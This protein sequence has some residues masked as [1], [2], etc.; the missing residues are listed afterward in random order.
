MGKLAP[1]YSVQLQWSDGREQ[2]D[3]VQWQVSG[4]SRHFYL[5]SGTTCLCLKTHPICLYADGNLREDHLLHKFGSHLSRHLPRLYGRFVVPVLDCR[6]DTMMADVL[7]LEKVG[8]T[9]IK[10]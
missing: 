3:V 9:L 1:G 5:F 7:V 10:P 2:V 8:P 6:G 4:Q